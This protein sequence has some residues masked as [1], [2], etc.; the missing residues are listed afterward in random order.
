MLFEWADGRQLVLPMI[1]KRGLMLRWAV[2]ASYPEAWGIG[3]VVGPSASDPDVIRDVFRYL[4]D[5]P[6]VRTSVRPNP[7][8]AATW[9][10]ACPS[11][12]ITIPT[13]AHVLDLTGGFD[14]VWSKRFTGSART[15]IRKAEKSGVTIEHDTTGRLMPVYYE[16]FKRSVD[17]WA[18]LQHEPRLLARWRASR[19]DPAEKLQMMARSLGEA[20]NVWVAW[21]DGKPAAA[22]VVLQ[23]QNAHY[24]RGAMNKE[25]A[26]PV[27]ANYLLHRM[28]I[29]EACRAGSNHYHM[30]ESGE[31]GSLAQFKS[32]FGAVALD[33]AEYRLERFPLTPIEHGVRGLVKR[34]IG[35][36][37][38]PEMAGPTDGTDQ[39]ATHA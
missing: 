11:G 6:A 35:F 17:R 29:E 15:A 14:H 8:A 13:R 4:A 25:L 38:V 10:A 20:C 39:S 19:R 16:L 2:Q 32:R 23:G 12:A 5:Q 27:R 31:S 36:R 7:R 26:G 28:A 18:G 24:T 33:Y 37:D 9:A 30:G 1:R 34:A 21:S 3:G 22:I